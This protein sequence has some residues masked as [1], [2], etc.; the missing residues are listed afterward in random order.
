LAK[1]HARFGNRRRN[2][3]HKVSRDLVDCFG[4]IAIEDLNLKGL[5]RSTL[6]K[7]VADASWAQL[8]ALLDDKAANAGVECVCADPCGTS[9]SSPEYGS[10]ATKAL[11]ERMCS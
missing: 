2:H 7:H 1:Y 11:A 5:A 9:Q 3:L 10:I 6:A 8:A 4:R